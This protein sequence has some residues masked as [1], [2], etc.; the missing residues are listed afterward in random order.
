MPNSLDAS[1]NVPKRP[2]KPNDPTTGFWKRLKTLNRLLHPCWDL[3]A[4]EKP[5]L[6]LGQR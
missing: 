6:L 2:E 4:W 3:V 1:G 5:P